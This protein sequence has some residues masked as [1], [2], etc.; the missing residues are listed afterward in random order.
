MNVTKEE[1]QDYRA[2]T[3]D[4]NHYAPGGVIAALISLSS[5]SKVCEVF[6]ESGQEKW[7]LVALTDTGVL[8]VT[9]SLDTGNDWILRGSPVELEATL[10]PYGEVRSLHLTELSMWSDPGQA[11]A[12]DFGLRLA[13]RD[14]T[15]VCAPSKGSPTHSQRDVLERMTVMLRER[16]A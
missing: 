6:S 9:G 13:F 5:G 2:K 8:T 16:L 4:A 3:L 14:G 7:R 12:W 10:R 15:E 11:W 1:L